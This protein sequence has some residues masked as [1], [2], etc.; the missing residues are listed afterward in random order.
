MQKNQ[1][2]K[3]TMYRYIQMYTL[4]CY[5]LQ[6]CQRFLISSALYYVDQK[7]LT[8]KDVLLHVVL[9]DEWVY[10]C[11][12]LVIRYLY[13]SPFWNIF[14][15]TIICYMILL[16]LFIFQSNMDTAEWKVMVSSVDDFYV[17]TANKSALTNESHAR[18][19]YGW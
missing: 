2:A 5:H 19:L 17:V 3:I 4:F 11:L 14:K 7:P 18:K 1:G 9:I 16:D 13:R 10:E 12:E 15:S 6:S 8:W